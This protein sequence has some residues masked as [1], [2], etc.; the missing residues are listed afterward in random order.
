[1]CIIITYFSTYR[2]MEILK[3]HVIFISYINNSPMRLN[4]RKKE[5]SPSENIQ[6]AF[7][8]NK[9]LYNCSKNHS[10]RTLK[11]NKIPYFI[12]YVSS[13]QI[14]YVTL[15]KKIGL[16]FH[17]VLTIQSLLSIGP[18]W[19]MRNVN[20][21]HIYTFLT[22]RV[23]ENMVFSKN[24]TTIQQC[25]QVSEK[26]VEPIWIYLDWNTSEKLFFAN[27]FCL[28]FPVIKIIPITFLNYRYK[29]NKASKWSA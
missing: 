1:M 11:I 10:I 4:F 23:L 14:S 28:R 25:I 29:H 16:M 2:V 7:P 26:R 27:F 6:P 22:Y 20:P 15:K 5:W 12:N 19:N 13:E 8:L 21:Y 9:F 24:I 18:Q 17:N 3:K